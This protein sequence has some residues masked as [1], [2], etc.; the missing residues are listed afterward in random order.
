MK[1]SFRFLTKKL[2]F[3]DH[4]WLMIIEPENNLLNVKSTT[5]RLSDSWELAHFNWI[6]WRK[7]YRYES[8]TDLY[9][10]KARNK[11]RKKRVKRILPDSWSN[12]QEMLNVKWAGNVRESETIMNVSVGWVFIWYFIYQKLSTPKAQAQFSLYV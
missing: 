10:K 9:T 4:T 8:C 2:G 1:F 7:W 6:F 12:N 3:S 11:Q 5:P